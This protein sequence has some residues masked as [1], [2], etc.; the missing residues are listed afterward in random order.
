[1]G[2]SPLV[3]NNEAGRAADVVPALFADGAPLPDTSDDDVGFVGGRFSLTYSISMGASC[4]IET[5][6]SVLALPECFRIESRR[7][8]SGDLS[9]VM[10]AD[11][12]AAVDDDGKNFSIESRRDKFG[13][14]V[15]DGQPLCV[16]GG[17]NAKSVLSKKREN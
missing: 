7:D 16:A 5:R 4:L 3:S 11:D 9:I 10:T 14:L 8:I 1:M 2:R 17:R 13:E 15:A 6:L 12:A